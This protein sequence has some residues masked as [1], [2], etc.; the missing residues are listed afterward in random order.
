M[1]NFAGRLKALA[2]KTGGHASEVAAA[3]ARLAPWREHFGACV[4]AKL[5]GLPEPGPEYVPYDGIEEDRELVDRYYP[6]DHDARARV[7]AKLDRISERLK[8][9]EN[10]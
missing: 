3:E 5:L 10:A 2:D 8:H 1:A 4:R 9:R 6:P 7:L